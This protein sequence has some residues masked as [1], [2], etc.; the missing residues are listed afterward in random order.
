MITSCGGATSGNTTSVD[1][2]G[3]MGSLG[4][5]TSASTGAS[6]SGNTTANVGSGTGGA[7]DCPGGPASFQIVPAP[8]TSWC[9]GSPEGCGW[10]P[11]FFGPNGE[12]SLGGFCDTQCETCSAT[13]CPPVGCFGPVELPDAGQLVVWDGHYMESGTCGV[14]Q[15]RCVSRSCSPAGRYRLQMCGF[16]RP[17]PNPNACSR[18]DSSTPTVCLDFEFDYPFSGV[19]TLVFP[20]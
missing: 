18:A 12:L 11:S 17:D 19:K 6:S 4:G 9:L 5:N 8:S 14:S 15:A 7:S 2:L 3:G 20:N 16:A 13:I 10:N 1:G